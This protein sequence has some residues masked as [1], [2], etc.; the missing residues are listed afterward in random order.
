MRNLKFVKLFA[1]ELVIISKRIDLL[2]LLWDRHEQLSISWLTGQEFLDNLLDVRITSRRTDL[3]ECI[4]ILEILLHFLFHFGLQVGRPELLREEI[5]LHLQLIWIFLFIGSLLSDLLLTLHAANPSFK[6]RFF[7]LNR[8]IQRTH[9]LLTLSVVF[10]DDQHERFESM[11]CLQAL[12]GRFALLISL[13][14]KDSEFRLVA[15]LLATHFNFHGD[16]VL[17]YALNHVFVLA[18]L[19]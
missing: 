1:P 14:L 6:R 17:L 10:I 7:V 19:H 18:L 12:L 2:L 15:F 8:L 11:L 3:L 5:L 4:L 16:K 9:L 13:F